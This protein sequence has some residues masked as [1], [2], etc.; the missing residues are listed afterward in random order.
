MLLTGVSATAHAQC[1]VDGG[2]TIVPA[3]A[4]ANRTVS[5]QVSGL[6]DDDLSGSQG[7]C[8]VFMEFVHGRL[9]NVRMTLTSPAGQSVIL[10]LIHI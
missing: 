6:A 1:F 8:A 5:L 9:P 2:V 10:S 4:I 7:I 3:A